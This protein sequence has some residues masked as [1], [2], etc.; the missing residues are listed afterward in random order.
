MKNMDILNLLVRLN[1]ND[2]Y[3]CGRKCFG[4]GNSRQQLKAS[5]VLMPVVQT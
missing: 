3:F 4:C 2:R 1:I 5:A